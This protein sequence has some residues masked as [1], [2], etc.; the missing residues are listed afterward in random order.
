MAKELIDVMA[1]KEISSSA[2]VAYFFVRSSRKSDGFSY[3]TNTELA[4]FLG[5]RMQHISEI[6]RELSEAN[7]VRRESAGKGKGRGKRWAL[8][9]LSLAVLTGAP[10][11]SDA[12]PIPSSPSAVS[13]TVVS[14]TRRRR[15]KRPRAIL[16]DA[17][18]SPAA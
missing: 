10:R 13:Q 15:R 7:L 17:A 3:I 12:Q 11:T 1:R 18:N 8:L 9:A 14:E 4:E 2:K 5:V 16:L 6:T